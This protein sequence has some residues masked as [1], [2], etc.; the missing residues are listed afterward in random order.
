MKMRCLMA[1]CSILVAGGCGDLP[2]D[3]TA[4]LILKSTNIITTDPGL[5]RAEAIAI[6]GDRI[7]A[8]GTNTDIQAFA[9]DATRTLSL[10]GAT[11]VPGPRHQRFQKLAGIPFPPVK[12]RS[13]QL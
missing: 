6:H 10:E 4:D 3:E 12:L 13:S 11:V 8:V 7:L 1:F 5:P 2:R 9:G